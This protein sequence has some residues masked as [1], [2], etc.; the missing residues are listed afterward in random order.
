MNNLVSIFFK[1]NLIIINNYSSDNSNYYFYDGYFYLINNNNIKYVIPTT[2]IIKYNDIDKLFAIKQPIDID[3]YE[4]YDPNKNIIT[5]K[6]IYHP[7]NHHFIKHNNNIYYVKDNYLYLLSDTKTEIYLKSNLIFHVDDNIFNKFI[8]CQNEMIYSYSNFINNYM[9]YGSDIDILKNNIDKYCD[10]FQFLENKDINMNE[11]ISFS[12]KKNRSNYPCYQYHNYKFS[13]WICTD[14]IILL[15]QNI[16]ICYFR[17]YKYTFDLQLIIYFLLRTNINSIILDFNTKYNLLYWTYQFDQNLIM[18]KILNYHKINYQQKLYDIYINNYNILYDNHINLTKQISKYSLTDLTT[19]R[20][21]CICLHIGN[22]YLA[23]DMF[24]YISKINTIY[25]IYIT[26]EHNIES[27]Y[28]FK[29]F[30]NNMEKICSK[31]TILKIDNYG[32]DIYPFLYV[33]RHFAE[34]DIKYDYLLKLH[35]KTE[36]AWRHNLIESIV[37]LPIDTII[38]NIELNGIYGYS[39]L[40]YDYLNHYYLKQL[41]TKLGFYIFDDQIITNNRNK[42][43]VN[44]RIDQFRPDINDIIYKLNISFDFVPGTMFWVKYDLIMSE[45]AIYNLCDDCKVDFKKDFIFQQILHAVERLFGI[46]RY[47]Y[48]Q[49]LK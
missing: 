14:T 37:N 39:Y 22:I 10:F 13:F 11:I 27:S 36:N 29:E 8:I 19:K 4:Y 40:K 31:I 35:T 20:N 21:I 23:Y 25:D 28:L 16:L 9:F 26:I 24:I 47:N 30:M 17:K 5:Y 42:I 12:Y 34:N 33:L 2:D 18:D 43:I 32:A 46:Y 48:L 15:P 49:Q 7:I 38:K 3:F 1:N 41:L 45:P 6:N 44:N